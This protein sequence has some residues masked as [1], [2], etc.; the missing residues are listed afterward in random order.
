MTFY[1]VVTIG[2]H[3]AP[4]GGFKQFFSSYGCVPTDLCG[5]AGLSLLS[6]EHP[7]VGVVRSELCPG[8]YPTE[9]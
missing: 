6:H 9:T 1:D 3:L 2:L 4:E 5:S 8:L 7:Q